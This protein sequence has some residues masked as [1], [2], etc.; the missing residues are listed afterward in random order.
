MTASDIQ[1]ILQEAQKNRGI[2]RETLLLHALKLVFETH[3]TTEEDWKS[4][5]REGQDRWYRQITALLKQLEF[6]TAGAEAYAGQSDNLSHI[7]QE[8]KR[9]MAEHQ[10]SAEVLRV[11]KSGLDRQLAD[12]EAGCARLQHDCREIQRRIE[13][14]KTES[15]RYRREADQG[16]QMIG[17]LEAERAQLMQILSDLKN[18]EMALSSET[19]ILNQQETKQQKQILYLNAE[20]IRLRDLIDRK[21]A[22]I[23][24]L[25]DEH[26]LLQE[27]QQV[28]AKRHQLEDILGIDQVHALANSE[29][30]SRLQQHQGQLDVLQQRIHTDLKAVDRLLTTEIGLNQKQLDDLRRLRF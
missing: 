14:L 4:A 15:D 11:Q 23:R 20:I 28:L 24:Q 17:A 13:A 27:L 7:V 19:G 21:D 30:I 10:A 26:N 29:L 6:C 9:R 18:R 1:N 2:D 16:K 12:T 25:T 8:L 22:N 5:S 3:V